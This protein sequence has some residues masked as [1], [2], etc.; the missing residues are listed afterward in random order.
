MAGEQEWVAEPAA[1]PVGRDWYRADLELHAVSTTNGRIARL[2]S[3]NIY[4]KMYR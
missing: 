3:R 1:Y 2:P 4:R